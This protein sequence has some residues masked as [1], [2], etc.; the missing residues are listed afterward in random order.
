LKEDGIELVF[1]P[2]LVGVEIDG[3]VRTA[4]RFSVEQR[5]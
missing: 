4:L 1:F 5:R 3:M 2:E